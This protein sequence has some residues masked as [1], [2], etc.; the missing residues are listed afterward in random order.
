M[1]TILLTWGNWVLIALIALTSL[2][3]INFWWHASFVEAVV[4]PLPPVFL[5]K[6]PFSLPSA[7]YEAIAPPPFSLQFSPLSPQLPDLRRYLGYHGK[8]G[9]PDIPP[10]QATLHFSA[11]GQKSFAS[12]LPKERLYLIYDKS[13]VPAQYLFSPQNS[14]TSF[15]IIAVPEGN[16]AAVE[17][18]AIDENGERLVT[19]AANLQ[20][21]LPERELVRTGP[22]G[23][24]W[25]IDGQRVD[26]TLF[27]RQKARWFGSDRFLEQHG[28]EEFKGQAG[29]QRIDF[30][31]KDN[32]YS[33]YLDAK[34]VLIWKDK[35]WQVVAP[36]PASQ[37][38]PLAVIKKI[39]ERI[40]TLDLWDPEGKIKVNLNLIKSGEAWNSQVIQQTF[41]Y[42]GART[43]HQFIFEV[44]NERFFIAP[45]DWLLLTPAGWKK[46]L[47]PSDVDNYVD[48]RL[49][50]ILFVFLGVERKEG[51]QFLIG[52]LYSPARSDMQNI[53]LQLKT[54]SKPVA[55]AGGGK[56][57]E[58][59]LPLPPQS[60]LKEQ[61]KPQENSDEN[62]DT[63]DSSES[64]SSE[65][66]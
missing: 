61:T 34:D 5:P 45:Y 19:P 39:D 21:K 6:N 20:V 27:V 1:A 28:G 12:V 42:E 23:N 46:L 59:R 51:K 41:T 13:L 56:A 37:G 4:E 14:P 16:T 57:A 7:A 11:T 44:N 36:G 47:S 43:R 17:L 62:D 60:P 49:T 10:E 31:D 2:L 52:E 25:E 9:R 15:W 38:Y 65:E 24:V 58:N 32:S 53:E 63:N 33:V 55:V 29:K 50:G 22:N 3:G 26:A 8:N 48:R 18:F 66:D 64:E 40:M 30:G 35:H 54:G